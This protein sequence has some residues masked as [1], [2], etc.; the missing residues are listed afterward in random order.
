MTFTGQ[1]WSNT[2]TQLLQCR[3]CFALFGFW[4]L[5]VTQNWF[6]D[7]GDSGDC[8]WPMAL[9][10]L[11]KTLYGYK[12]E[13]QNKNHITILPWFCLGGMIPGSVVAVEINKDIFKN[14][15]KQAIK[16]VY[17]WLFWVNG[18]RR[19]IYVIQVPTRKKNI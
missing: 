2:S 7:L 12:N 16:V 17:A 15:R 5:H 8:N 4:I 10:I 6:C 19:K 14:K 11:I 13:Y 9:S 1:W 3:Q 18:A